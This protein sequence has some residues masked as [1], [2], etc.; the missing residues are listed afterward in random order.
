MAG[1][2][3]LALTPA[4][5]VWVTGGT[6]SQSFP[7]TPDAFQGFYHAGGTF[8]GSSDA[9]LT[10]L[11]ATGSAILYSTYLGGIQTDYGTDVGLD[12]A[13]NVYVA[14][15]TMSADFPTTANAFSRVFKGAWIFSGETPSSPSWR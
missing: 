15:E 13:G 7:T 9:F 10:E 1:S 12:L 5:N 14:G 2:T 3:G 11:N 8:E 6:S 4:G